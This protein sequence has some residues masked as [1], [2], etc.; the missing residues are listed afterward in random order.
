[1]V[2]IG[3]GLLS[4]I[5]NVYTFLFAAITINMVIGMNHRKQILSGCG[6]AYSKD[7]KQQLC[8]LFLLFLMSF[9]IVILFADISYS[10]AQILFYNIDDNELKVHYINLFVTIC[11]MFSNLLFKTMTTFIN[12]NGVKVAERFLKLNK[13]K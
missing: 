6:C 10:L 11:V 5:L 9:G 8:T 12:K 2:L 4:H 3:S 7:I 1:M 13:D